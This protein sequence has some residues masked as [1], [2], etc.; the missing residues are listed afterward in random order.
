MNLREKGNEE[1]D[2]H[3][4]TC[5]GHALKGIL[6]KNNNASKIEFYKERSV[7]SGVLEEYNDLNV[8]KSWSNCA[9]YVMMED[10]S[11][12]YQIRSLDNLKFDDCEDAILYEVESFVAPL[13]KHVF[14]AAEDAY[15]ISVNL[16]DKTRDSI[17]E[18]LQRNGI[19][20][21]YE[22]VIR[23]FLAT[24]RAYKDF[25]VSKA[26]MIEEKTFYSQVAFPKFVWICEYGTFDTYNRHK[27]LG[28]FVLDATS[29]K[30]HIFE[31]V[32]SI[33]NGDSITYRGPV[34]SREYAHLRRS[35]P[36]AKEY[37]MYEQNN[38]K[39]TTIEGR[40]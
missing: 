26:K 11:S 24:S 2:N 39:L 31:P 21:P 4:V 23:L 29:A 27:A 32:I 17:V 25:R 37:D 34:D 13:Y 12:P 22:I 5:V 16:I 10:H 15:E 3:S 35:I 20:A 7:D 19:N 6:E 8:F 28:E 33:R 9:G 1:G 36:V 38:L 14:M 40:L 30:Y 18:G